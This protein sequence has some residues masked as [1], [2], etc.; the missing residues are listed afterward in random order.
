[1]IVLNVTYKCKAGRLYVL[2]SIAK[3]ERR[4]KKWCVDF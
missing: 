1:M 2:K 3:N 4:Y